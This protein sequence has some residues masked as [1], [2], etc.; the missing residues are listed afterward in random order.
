MAREL[1]AADRAAMTPYDSLSALLTSDT[2]M[3]GLVRVVT[4]YV[5]DSLSAVRD[6]V[7]VITSTSVPGMRTDTIIIIR[8]RV[9]YPIPLR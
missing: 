3:S 1:A 5:V 4:R 8:G 9:R 7:Y 6:D 2:V